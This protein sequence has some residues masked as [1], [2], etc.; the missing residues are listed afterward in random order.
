MIELNTWPLSL[1]QRSGGGAEGAKL[2]ITPFCFSGDHL[3]FWSC[4]GILNHFISLLAY[5]IHSYDSRDSRGSRSCLPGT[6]DKDQKYIFKL[7]SNIHKMLYAKTAE[8]TLSSLHGIF[9]IINYILDHE[10]HYNKFK[11]LE[12][13]QCILSD[14]NSIKPEI[15]NKVLENLKI[16][17]DKTKHSKI[18]N[19]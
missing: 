2:I 9:V 18:T 7:Y 17:G 3:P 13:I 6:K 4:L 10:A 12:T 16:C 19:E 1:P 15:N 5:V 8:Y 11:W 14:S